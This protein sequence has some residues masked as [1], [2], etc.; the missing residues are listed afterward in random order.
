MRRLVSASDPIAMVVGY[1]DVA[2]IADLERDRVRAFTH[3]L[4]CLGPVQR[5]V[6][7]PIETDFEP[8]VVLGRHL[9]DTPRSLRICDV[10]ASL[11]KRICSPQIGKS[12]AAP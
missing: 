4:L 8:P 11:C 3:F 7:D 5:P 1:Q 6:L 9:E 10:E 2:G 12:A